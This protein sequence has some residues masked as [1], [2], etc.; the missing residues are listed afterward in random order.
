MFNSELCAS[1][2]EAVYLEENVEIA[3]K[4]RFLYSVDI[5]IIPTPGHTDGGLS[6]FYRSAEGKDILFTGDTLF[7]SNGKLSTFVYPADGGNKNDMLETLE[8]YR[9]IKPNV[10]ISSGYSGDRC[11]VE[12]DQLE[13]DSTIDQIISNV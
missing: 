13:W 2:I 1:E 4:E 5:E 6:F 12:I 9:N 3:V 10:V 11:V 8:I 7:L